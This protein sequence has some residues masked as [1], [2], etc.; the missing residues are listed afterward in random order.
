MLV[1]APCASCKSEAISG[2]TS[3]AVG[4]AG[5]SA[6]EAASR[7]GSS[8]AAGGHSGAVGE[9][10]DGGAGTSTGS[11]ATAGAGGSGAG[12]SGAD[13]GPCSDG[14]LLCDGSC[15]DPMEDER[16][17]GASGSCL[18]KYRGHRCSSGWTCEDGSC[19]GTWQEPEIVTD[20]GATVRDFAMNDDG[21]AIFAWAEPT[22][23]RRAKVSRRLYTLEEGWGSAFIRESYTAAELGVGIDLEGNAIVVWSDDDRTAPNLQASHYAVGSGWGGNEF[24]N[25]DR[26]SRSYLPNMAMAA[27]GSSLVVWVEE[28]GLWARRHTLDGGWEPAVLVQPGEVRVPEVAMNRAGDAIAVWYDLASSGLWSSRAAA[29]KG[30]A[31]SEQIDDSSNDSSAWLNRDFD[32]A[33][34]AEGNALVVWITFD[35]LWANRFTADAGWE[36]PQQLDTWDDAWEMTE[37]GMDAEGNALVA[38]QWEH[39]YISAGGIYANEYTVDSGWGTAADFTP[40]EYAGLPSLAVGASG[41]ALFVW[42]TDYEWDGDWVSQIRTRRYTPG[43]GFGATESVDMISCT[44]GLIYCEGAPVVHVAVDADGNALLLWNSVDQTGMRSS[45]SLKGEAP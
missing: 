43:V 3:T 26:A 1:G 14:L 12:G 45:L 4:G 15:I 22:S 34:D 40:S 33:L 28:D 20:I 37:I 18:G 19:P 36:G 31:T 6:G 10:G 35:D 29:G 27:D 2:D 30:W 41:E 39:P 44:E 17:C 32:A 25:V 5:G 24:V 23:E 7:G 38:W 16:F 11:G 9:G 21:S 42:L 8:G 13:G